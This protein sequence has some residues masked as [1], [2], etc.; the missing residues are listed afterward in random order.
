MGWDTDQHDGPPIGWARKAFPRPM[1]SAKSSPRGAGYPSC[2]GLPPLT[3][4]QLDRL[5]QALDQL[6][7]AG[8]WRGDLPV[9]L[10]DR[11]W[12]RLHAVPVRD[13][14]RHLPPDSSWDAPELAHYRLLLEQGHSPMA[15]EQLCWLDYGQEACRQAQR[16][17]WSAQEWGNN[18]WTLARYLQ[19]LA[20]Y[21]QGFA[22]GAARALPLLVLARPGESRDAQ[23]QVIWIGANEGR[24]LRT[25]RHTCP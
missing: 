11:C 20:D 13:L 5:L 24:T 1:R 6:K 14:A 23:H 21:R 7:A 16:R 15:A 22:D 10:L 12:L 25:M 9:L 8:A 3:A 18:G 2:A 4:R 17:L 19:L